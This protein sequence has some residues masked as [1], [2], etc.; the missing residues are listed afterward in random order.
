[1]ALMGKMMLLLFF[2]LVRLHTAHGVLP[3]ELDCT[4]DGGPAS[5]DSDLLRSASLGSLS[6]GGFTVTVDGTVVTPESQIT[7][8]LGENV[9]IALSR[10]GFQGYLFRVARHGAGNPFSLIRLDA[11]DVGA[12][13]FCS[14]LGLLVS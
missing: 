6:D 1:M 13:S 2:V 9:D 8:T 12:A 10:S 4:N 5:V 3:E 7:A 11:V 14:A